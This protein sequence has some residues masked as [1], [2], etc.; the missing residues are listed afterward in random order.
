[1]TLIQLLVL[2]VVISGVLGVLLYNDRL[3]PP[4]PNPP[5]DRRKYRIWGK[6][7]RP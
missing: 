1:M 2:G 6:E 7:R 5:P 3:H 4:P